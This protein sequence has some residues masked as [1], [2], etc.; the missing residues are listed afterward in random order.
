MSN[1]VENLMNE[2][3]FSNNKGVPYYFDDKEKSLYVSY[4]KNATKY[5]AQYFDADYWIKDEYSN[6]YHVSIRIDILGIN[7]KLYKRVYATVSQPKSLLTMELTTGAKNIGSYK[8]KNELAESFLQEI[9]KLYNKE[10]QDITNLLDKLPTI[11]QRSQ[12][13]KIT[14]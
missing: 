13:L 6:E 4:T 8:T 3:L 1:D 10:P 14:I 5:Q 11:I 7:R 12:P 2:L 9:K